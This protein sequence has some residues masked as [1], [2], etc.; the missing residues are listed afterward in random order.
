MSIVSEI[1]RIKTNI[2]NAYTEVEKMGAIMPNVKNSYNLASTLSTLTESSDITDL[3]Y[4][5][6]NDTMFQIETGKIMPTDEEY[7]QII[8][9]GYKILD[10][11]FR[12]ETI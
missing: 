12:G 5:K 11:V 4:I 3:D 9:N 7:E 1:V 8:N 6:Y 10:Y 2:S